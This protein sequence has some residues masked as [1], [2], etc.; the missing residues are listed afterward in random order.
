LTGLELMPLDETHRKQKLTAANRQL[1]RLSKLVD[2]LLNVSRIVHGT[3]RLEREPIDLAQLA[4][5]VADRLADEFVR[6]ATPLEIDSPA[7]V[8]GNWDRLR[9]DLVISNLL[10]NA[11]RYGNR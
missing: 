9:I 6:G 11:L 10:S 1:R 7:P 3:L 4:A 2:E 5:E 8:T